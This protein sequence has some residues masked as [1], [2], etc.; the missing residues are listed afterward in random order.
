MD[1]A[2]SSVP[3]PDEIF[4]LYHKLGIH[5]SQ[6]QGPEFKPQYHPQKQKKVSKLA[7]VRSYR[8]L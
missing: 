6:T 8:T 7:K 5:C 2:L 1:K 4:Y 3:R